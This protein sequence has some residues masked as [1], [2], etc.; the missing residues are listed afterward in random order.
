MIVKNNKYKVKGSPRQSFSILFCPVAPP[1][2]SLRR[3]MS[4]STGTTKKY[5]SSLS[6]S[7]SGC[8]P[9]I[10]PQ[11]SQVVAGQLH[12]APIPFQVVACFLTCYHSSPRL[13]P[14]IALRNM[15][16]SSQMETVTWEFSRLELDHL[17]RVLKYLPFNPNPTHIREGAASR[18]WVPHAVSAGV[19]AG[20]ESWTLVI[21]I[22]LLWF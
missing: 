17:D 3:V 15:I 13:R 22:F 7:R 21:S 16:S 19:V 2:S 10:Y 18:S 11:Q 8:M 12:Q 6:H 1:T 9:R 14:A 4:S 20:A 5:R